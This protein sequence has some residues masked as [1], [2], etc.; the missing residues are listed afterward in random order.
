[1]LINELNEILLESI[2]KIGELTKQ[3]LIGNN[4]E[5]MAKNHELIRRHANNCVK[6]FQ[7]LA[8]L[9]HECHIET[10]DER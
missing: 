5:T 7:R 1:M 10:T 9:V 3:E 6:L 8:S 4:N 2:T